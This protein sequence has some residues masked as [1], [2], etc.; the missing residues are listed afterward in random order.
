MGSEKHAMFHKV[1]KI[2]SGKNDKA[3]DMAGVLA[4]VV[5]G[6]PI[7]G[8][9]KKPEAKPDDPEPPKND[10]QV[11]AYKDN[12]NFKDTVMQIQTK[13]EARSREREKESEA[14][15]QKV[16]E[17]LRTRM[18]EMKANLKKKA[19]LDQKAAV[20]KYQIAQKKVNAKIYDTMRSQLPKQMRSVI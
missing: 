15:L 11:D 18:E 4:D 9:D 6:K 5:D 10:D 16:V 7:P 14:K 12:V 8:L 17:Q 1:K 19:E 13:L 3:R 2:L 20:Q